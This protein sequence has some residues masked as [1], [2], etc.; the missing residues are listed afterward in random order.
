L[1][2]DA[3]DF[4]H[5]RAC[6]R[7]TAARTTRGVSTY[8]TRTHHDLVPVTRK[9]LKWSEHHNTTSAAAATE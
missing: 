4:L 3:G 9:R 2:S 8:P 6:A 1:R 7:A 5:H